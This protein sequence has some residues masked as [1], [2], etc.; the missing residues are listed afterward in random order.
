MFNFCGSA[1][2]F[3]KAAAPFTFPSAVHKSFRFSISSST[4]IFSCLFLFCFNNSCPNGCAWYLMALTYIFLMIG[5]VKHFYNAYG[6]LV[7]L[8][9]NIYPSPLPVFNFF[10]LNCWVCSSLFWILTPY[11]IYPLQIFLSFRGLLFHFVNCVL[12]CR[13]LN[14]VVQFI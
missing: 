9:R 11:Q 14:F 3:S 13:V 7:Y 8:W 4:L 10:F 5:D 2:L 6:L 1:T 12:W